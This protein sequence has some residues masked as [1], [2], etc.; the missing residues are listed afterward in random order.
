MFPLHT[1][2]FPP[3]PAALRDAIEESLRRVVTAQSQI[4][5]IEDKTYPELRAI[6]L[7]VDNARTSW[8]PPR[9]MPATGPIE[10]ALR[11]EYFEITGRPIMVERAAI[12]LVCTARDVQIGQGRAADG[13]LVLVLQNAAEGNVGIVARVAELEALLLAGAR[14]EA[15]KRGITVEDLKLDLRSRTSRALGVQVRVQARKL[16]LNAT[17][18]FSGEVEIDDRLNARLSGLSCTAEGALGTL[19]CNLLGPHLERFNHREFSLLAL[20]LGEVELREI[21]IAVDDRLAVTASFG[22][23]A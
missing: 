13:N 15:G 2:I 23:A 20:P 14:A 18:C 4:V 1:K 5:V 12:D 8:R 16:L 19:A 22:R 21:K 17:V 6:R 7:S 9:P 11:V 3:D 10:P